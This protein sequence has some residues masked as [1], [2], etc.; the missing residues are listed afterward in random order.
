[1]KLTVISRIC[2]GKSKEKIRHKSKNSKPAKTWS[3]R[4]TR[5]VKR[6]TQSLAISVEPIV[7]TGALRRKSQAG[8]RVREAEEKRLRRGIINASSRISSWGRRK[9]WREEEYAKLANVRDEE[10]GCVDHAQSRQSGSEEKRRRAEKLQSP[11]IPT[12]KLRKRGVKRRN[13]RPCRA[14]S[15]KINA[16]TRDE[17]VTRKAILLHQQ[18]I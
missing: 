2:L 11:A 14:Y 3:R 1:M 18:S 7:K 5:C 4:K 8:E 6:R 16:R 10:N 17:E 12:C 15:R 9:T 13:Q